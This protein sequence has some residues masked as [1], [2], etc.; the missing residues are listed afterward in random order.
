MGLRALLGV[1]DV[2]GTYRA[3]HVHYDGSP[4][5]IVPALTALVHNV[6]DHDRAAAADHLLRTNWRRLYALPGTGVTGELVGTPIESGPE[7][8]TG[9]IG[10][11]SPGDREWAYLFGGHRL[12]V[13]L[14]LWPETGQ[15]Q[16]EPWACWSVNE[17][18]DVSRV[19]LL[20]VRKSG[21]WTAW[22][23]SDYRK[24]MSAVAEAY[25]EERR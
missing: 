18:P 22:R 8:E 12:H 4:D 24:Y 1:E 17:L 6:L 9:Q 10:V 25:G 5:V 21:A 16:W 13:Y 19:E 11:T 23:A 20:D 2:G 14:G 15:K 3:R 7:P